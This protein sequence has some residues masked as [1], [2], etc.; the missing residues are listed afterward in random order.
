MSLD[1]LLA[2]IAAFKMRLVIHIRPE[3]DKLTVTVQSGYPKGPKPRFGSDF[4][5][6]EGLR[7]A[8][9]NVA[10]TTEYYWAESEQASGYESIIGEVAIAEYDDLMCNLYT[11]DKTVDE[12]RQLFGG[13]EGDRSNLA[14]YDEIYPNRE[15]PILRH[16]DGK[17]TLEKHIW[18]IP[19]FGNVKRPITNVRNLKS[20]FW[21]N[22]LINPDRR[23]LVPVSRFCEWEGEKGSKR[24]VWFA[25][26]DQSPFAFA[27]IWRPTE[28]GPRMA[29][30]TT[31]ANEIVG[32]VHPKAM[33]VILPADGYET[34]LQGDWE[35]AAG[36]VRSYPDDQM[37][38]IRDA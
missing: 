27:G 5:I 25:M 35:E 4:P 8:I 2:R 17:L 19:G 33:P 6:N 34:W 24:K 38:I 26:R 31:D 12:L 30:L 3:N 22:M 10:A 13:F 32:T 36:L 37:Q 21:R 20:N 28:E 15:A 14:S 29:F 23:C 1:A 11:M 18:G 16:I 7:N 9:D